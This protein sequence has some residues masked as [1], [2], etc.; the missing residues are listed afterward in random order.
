MTNVNANDIMKS[1]LEYLYSILNGG[2]DQVPPSPDTFLTFCSPG[3]PFSKDAF[4]FAFRPL[5]SARDQNDANN[6]IR[7]MREFAHLVDQIPDPGAF[8]DKLAPHQSAQNRLSEMYKQILHSSKIVDYKLTDAEAATLKKAEDFLK[9]EKLVDEDPFD[10]LPGEM[11]PVDT[12]Q[13]TLYKQKERAHNDAKD[14]YM[15]RWLDAQTLAG[16]EGKRAAIMWTRMGDLYFKEYLNALDDWKVNGFKNTV[17]LARAKVNQLTEKSMVLWK[18]KLE[19]MVVKHEQTDSQMINF[20]TTTVIPSNFM[21]Q[22]WQE[23]TFSKDVYDR[24]HSA[25]ETSWR[26]GAAFSMGI[27]SI[28]GGARGENTKAEFS[29]DKEKFKLKMRLCK[30]TIMRP[31]FYPEFFQNRGWDLPAGAGWTWDK[32]PSNGDVNNPDG[33]FIAYPTEVILARDIEIIS[34]DFKSKFNSWSE[35]VKGAAG[36]SIG[37]FSFGGG[38]GSTSSG[39][40]YHFEETSQGFK[41][42]NVQLIGFV[43]RLIPKAPNLL[44]TINQADLV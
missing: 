23:Y 28:G 22:E 4:D 2:N 37:P 39:S 43:N 26:A 35:T 9:T 1:F 6:L 8:R 32:K 42:K 34:E 29:V 15:R 5:G 44:P 16:E 31:W 40:E 18:Q 30:V 24:K 38:G 25:S 3:T 12:A 13:V 21:R 11:T 19:N 20:L 33:M 14:L 36:F 27:F 17:E 41:S 10:E 7:Q